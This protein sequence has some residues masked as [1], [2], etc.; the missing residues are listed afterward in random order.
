MKKEDCEFQK[1]CVIQKLSLRSC[2]MPDRMRDDGFFGQALAQLCTPSHLQLPYGKL[3]LDVPE[4]S[5]LLGIDR[6]KIQYMMALVMGASA[7]AVP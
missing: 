6:R 7:A 5:Q 1:E 3:S 2:A 4:G